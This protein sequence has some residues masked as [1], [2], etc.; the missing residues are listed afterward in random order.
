MNEWTVVTV[1]ATLI[2]LIAAIIKPLISLNTSITRLTGAVAT[3][4]ENIE[5]FGLKNDQSHDKFSKKFE[6]QDAAINDHE[7]RITVIEL[8]DIMKQ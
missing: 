7:T 2:G 3:L 8:N 6:E 4:K 1:I 5:S